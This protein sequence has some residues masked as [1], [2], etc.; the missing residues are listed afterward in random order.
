MEM[1]IL[2]LLLMVHGKAIL[3]NEV[4]ESIY[5]FIEN[6][7]I[8]E[9]GPINNLPS[10]LSNVE[11]IDIPTNQNVVPGFIDVHIHG[12]AGA[13]TMDATIDALETIAKA[14]PAEG[15]TSFLAT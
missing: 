7:K 8:K 2:S 1:K 6:G 15:T 12:A 11:K 14:L 10:H 5:I 13:D 3:E 4:A 9:L